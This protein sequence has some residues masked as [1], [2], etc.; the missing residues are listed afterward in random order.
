MTAPRVRLNGSICW[1][2]VFTLCTAKTTPSTN[3]TAPVSR[4]R[5]PHGFISSCSWTD[6]ITPSLMSPSITNIF[7]SVLYG[8]TSECSNRGRAP[9]LVP[10]PELDLVDTRSA[11]WIRP[12]HHHAEIIVGQFRGPIQRPSLYCT[13]P[14]KKSPDVLLTNSVLHHSVKYGNFRFVA[15]QEKK[16]NPSLRNYPK[17]WAQLWMP[18]CLYGTYVY[19]S[20]LTPTAMFCGAAVADFCCA[21]VPRRIR[22]RMYSIFYGTHR[23]D[24]SAD[25]LPPLLS[26]AVASSCIL[27]PQS[28]FVRSYM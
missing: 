1:M 26:S 18:Q 15:W 27:P 23:Y 5:S 6:R 3:C 17:N 8:P 11:R 20:M 28:I 12:N 19:S 25:K 22:F 14:S 7:S 21:S 10:F 9:C 24:R 2:N 13:L 16:K 4:S